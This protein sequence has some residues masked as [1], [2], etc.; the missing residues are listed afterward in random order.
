MLLIVFK[1]ILRCRASTKVKG[2][3][4]TVRELILGMH[5]AGERM[6]KDAR[7]IVDLCD[8]MVTILR[9]GDSD[10]PTT[11]LVWQAM[12]NLLEHAQTTTLGS[13]KKRQARR[14]EIVDIIETRW[15]FLHADIYAAGYALNPVNMDVNVG[16][17]EEIMTGLQAMLKKLLK[18]EEYFTSLSEFADFKARL[19]ATS[20]EDA[21]KAGACIEPYKWWLTFGATKPCLQKAAVNILSQ[22]QRHLL[23]K[24]TGRPTIGS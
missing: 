22:N 6:W 5:K 10:K 8:P 19:G 16:G 11:G 20:T 7:V 12:A 15:E 14:D 4:D 3:V 9:M 2:E 18:P 24:E 23:V 21:R 17:D 13:E 1:C